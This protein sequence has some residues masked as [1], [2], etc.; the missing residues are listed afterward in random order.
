M[1]HSP[2]DISRLAG[3]AGDIDIEALLMIARLEAAAT[4]PEDDEPAL[5]PPEIPDGLDLHH[6]ADFDWL[7]RRVEGA[8]S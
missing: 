3:S 8:N 6:W 5:S 2:I 7:E 1:D 4:W